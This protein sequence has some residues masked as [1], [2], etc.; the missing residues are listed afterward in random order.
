M[1]QQGT[2]SDEIFETLS[3][4]IKTRSK[5]IGADLRSLKAHESGKEDLAMFK[6]RLAL[7]EVRKESLLKL[8]RDHEVE[9]WAVESLL[10][11]IDGK[12]HAMTAEYK[13]QQEESNG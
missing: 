12:L 10:V 3:K 6:T 11:D 9:P 2:V 8:I 7:L 5:A 4:E 1:K 13:M